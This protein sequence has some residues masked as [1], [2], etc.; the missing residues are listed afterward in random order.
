MLGANGVIGIG[1]QAVG[2]LKAAGG[3]GSNSRKAKHI[4][5]SQVNK[6]GKYNQGN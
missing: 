3:K 6:S 1:N 5:Q 4:P 2:N